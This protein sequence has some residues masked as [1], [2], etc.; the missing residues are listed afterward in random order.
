MLAAKHQGK[1]SFLHT[2]HLIFLL[3][4]KNEN[5]I[6]SVALFIELVSRDAIC[7]SPASLE[8]QNW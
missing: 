8:E 5:P 1:D 7:T 2:R 3:W 4:E 6:H